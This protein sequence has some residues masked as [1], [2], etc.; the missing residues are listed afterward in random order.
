MVNW[1]VSGV[2]DKELSMVYTQMRMQS[3][4]MGSLKESEKTKRGFILL[5]GHLF[6]LFWK[7]EETD[8]QTKKSE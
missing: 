6:L 2:A 7:C 1:R 8:D 3:V 4:R 5:T